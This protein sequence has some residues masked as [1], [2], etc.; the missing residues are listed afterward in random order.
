MTYGNCD[1]EYEEQRTIIDNMCSWPIVL[2]YRYSRC[3]KTLVVMLNQV[4]G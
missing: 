1:I 2:L 3:D 4:V